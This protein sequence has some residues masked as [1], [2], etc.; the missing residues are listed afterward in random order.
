MSKEPESSAKLPKTRS[1]SYPAFSLSEAIGKL[2]ALYAAMKRHEVAPETAISAMGLSHKGSTGKLALAAMRSFGLIEGR[3]AVKLS[4]RGLDIGVDY[5][6][7]DASWQQAAKDAALAPDMHK[8]LWD[9]YGPDLPIDDELRR[10]LVREHGFNDNVVGQF[11][12]D[13]KKT[14]EFSGLA[15]DGETEKN[16]GIPPPPSVKVGDYVQWTS[17]GTDR[18]P[19]PKRVAWLSEDG[20]FARVEGN[21]TGLPVMELAL[22]EPG[23]AE[24]ERVELENDLLD[25]DMPPND[26]PTKRVKVEYVLDEGKVVLLWP[27][28]LSKDSFDEF[29]YWMKGLLKRARRKAGIAEEPPSK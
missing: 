20:K 28:E 25:F 27:D 8:L 1:P 15:N 13:Y 24:Q 16:E 11:V 5:K 23:V 22:K 10:F 18:F 17:A 4:R 29:E 26:S 19:Q 6:P 3:G 2:P 7:T 14:I 9:K 12:T 21:N